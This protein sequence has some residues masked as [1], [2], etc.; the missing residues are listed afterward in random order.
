[1]SRLRWRDLTKSKSAI[2]VAPAAIGIGILTAS[3]PKVSE[4]FILA[5]ISGIGL[6]VGARL[7]LGGDR[8]SR[9][10]GS[11]GSEVD[12]QMTTVA[13]MNE[14]SG[15]IA[16]SGRTP[17]FIFYMGTLTIGL[18][19]LRIGWVTLS[20]VLFLA[21]FLLCLIRS[22]GHRQ[23]APLPGLLVAGTIIYTLGALLASSAT[24]NPLE[25]LAVLARFAYLSLAWFWLASYLLSDIAKLE[26]AVT[27]WVASAA[28]SGAGSLVQL[29]GVSI[30]VT[31]VNFYGRMI[32]FTQHPNDLGGLTGIALLPALVLASRRRISW[33]ARTFSLLALSLVAIGLLLSG[34]VGGLIAAIVA[35]LLWLS[36]ADRRSA[37]NAIP[38]LAFVAA[39]LLISTVANLSNNSPIDRVATTTA[40]H[41]SE[42]ATFWTREETN[43]AALEWLSH[44]PFIGVGLDSSSRDTKTGMEVHNLLLG[45]WFTAGLLGLVGMSLVLLSLFAASRFVLSAIAGQRLGFHASIVAAFL[46]SLV[47]AMSAPIIHQRYAWTAA[48]LVLA[49]RR[50]NYTHIARGAVELET[51]RRSRAPN[52]TTTPHL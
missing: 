26:K 21:A 49:C 1:M 51:R 19:A 5:S 8:N 39:I 14:G 35:T 25:S 11:E 24:P 17:E 15:A 22:G 42:G 13:G 44:H 28:L 4:Y 30:F 23:S 27:L 52:R 3:L 47:F 32:G 10:E 18:P 46:G 50:L 2:I 31:D 34:S 48:A 33:R 16:L 20:D 45:A 40:T 37:L 7:L 12:H 6:V 38:I 43:R 41:G 9:L 36:L 29:L